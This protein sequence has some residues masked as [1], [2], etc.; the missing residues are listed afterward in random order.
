MH[1]TFGHLYCGSWNKIST[2]N[3]IL[4]T[5]LFIS[6]LMAASGLAEQ[7]GPPRQ[8]VHALNASSRLSAAHPTGQTL[9]HVG[10]S[11]LHVI[12]QAVLLV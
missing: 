11:V 1:D 4:Q 7:F 12:A 2:Q 8:L 5:A 9:D 10:F 3:H 6:R